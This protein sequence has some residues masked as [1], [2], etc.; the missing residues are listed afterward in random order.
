MLLD[1]AEY[2]QT[3]EKSHR[4][5]I[6]AYDGIFLDLSYA[7]LEPVIRVCSHVT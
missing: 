7:T 2:L 5:N 4:G 6:A 3:H 1:A